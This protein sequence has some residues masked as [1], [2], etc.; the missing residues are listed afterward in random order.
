MELLEAGALHGDDV[1]K[2]AARVP[3][4][5]RYLGARPKEAL[6][7]AARLGEEGLHLEARVPGIASR[8]AQNFGNNELALLAKKPPQEVTRLVGLAER[9]DSAKTRAL[10]LNQWKRRGTALLDELDQ[11]KMLILTAGLTASML[12]VADGVQDTIQAMPEKAPE[13]LRA[14]T[15]KVGSGLSNFFVLCG[16]GIPSVIAFRMWLRRPV[17]KDP[18]PEDPSAVG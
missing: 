18:H 15:D 12:M 7:L 3:E 8:A 6:D 5:A 14:F 17:R 11:R 16:I 10:L 2:L 9:A 13:T 1:F 4:A